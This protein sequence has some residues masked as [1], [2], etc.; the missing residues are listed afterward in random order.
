MIKKSD[1]LCLESRQFELRLLMSLVGYK[2]LKIVP[3]KCVQIFEDYWCLNV[4]WMQEI[5]TVKQI[6]TY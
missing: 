2:E 3:M 1:T 5:R 4:Y 6:V